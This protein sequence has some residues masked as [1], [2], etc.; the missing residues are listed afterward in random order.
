MGIAR[1]FFFL[2]P[3]ALFALSYRTID[4]EECGSAHILEVKRGEAEI[5]PALTS[6]LA[7][8]S[9]IA[10]SYRAIAAINGGFFH[11]DGTPSGMLKIDGCVY[12]L[13]EKLRGAIGWDAEEVRFGK[14][15]SDDW[16]DL[17]N[18]VGGAP[19]LIQNGHII[20]D[21]SSEQV[22][23]SFLEK[24]CPRTAVGVLENGDWLFVVIEKMTINQLAHFMYALGCTDAL[25]LDG[26]GSSTFYYM[27]EVKNT[28]KNE[29]ERAIS[30]AI[31]IRQS[32]R[33][34][35]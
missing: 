7:T 35:N 14:L 25:N 2:F 9:E 27:G 28:L 33:A 8:V 24:L 3:L 26:G 10:K 11:F 15:A 5:F 23:L 29:C 12:G 17:K 1:I 31:I 20:E 34:P 6:D 16:T 13:P 18:V 4:K 21:F 32:A 30:N 19:L 22:R